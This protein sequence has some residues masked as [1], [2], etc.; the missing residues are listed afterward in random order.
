MAAALPGLA[1]VGLLPPNELASFLENPSA[2]VRAAALLSL[3]LRRP[4]PAD[5]KQSVLDRLDDPAR[6]VREAA[7]LAAVAFRMPEAV[8]H[9][10][11]LAGKPDPADRNRAIAALCR[12]PDPRAASIYLAAIRDRDPRLRRAAESA[13]LAIRDRVSD[14]IAAAARSAEFSGPA[15]ISLERILARFEPIREWRVIGPF[16]RATPQ[17]FLG[18]RSIDFARAQTGADGQS[19]AWRTRRA[20]PKTGRVTLDDLQPATGERGGSGY[21]AGE[22]PG[23]VA[24]AYAEV[25]SH[26]EGAGLLLLGSSGPLI[27][28][29]NEQVVANDAGVAG[30][31]DAPNAD[32]VR[33]RLARGRNRILVQSRQ[34]IGPWSFGVQVARSPAPRPTWPAGEPAGRGSQP[35][36][37]AAS[38][39]PTKEMPGAARRSSSIPAGSAAADA[40]RPAAGARPRS[41]RI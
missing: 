41:V 27:V 28:T 29:V 25:D 11:A 35:T 2:A 19:I 17:V 20:D 16:P 14:Q 24:F 26:S 30:R 23:L 15:A 4:M 12:L 8:P 37:C 39:W 10:L 13:L 21:D 18:E 6:E 36:T 5:V 7:I 31:P 1:G 9:L 33:F 32:L 34:G 3:N 38:R 22:S 40:T